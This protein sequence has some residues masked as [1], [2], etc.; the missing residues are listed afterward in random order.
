M[1]R[2]SVERGKPGG[3]GLSR[4]D[5]RLRMETRGLAVATRDDAQRALPSE[6]EEA[7][8][9]AGDP[10]VDGPGDDRHRDGLARVERHDFR[11][12]A[13][14]GEIMA[15]DGEIERADRDGGK[16]ADLDCLGAS[17][18]A[19]HGRKGE[20]DDQRGNA[21]SRP[22]AETSHAMKSPGPNMRGPGNGCR[23]TGA[24]ITTDRLRASRR[25]SAPDRCHRRPGSPESPKAMAIQT[26][27]GD[28]SLN[29]MTQDHLL[30][31]VAEE[32]D[33]SRVRTIVQ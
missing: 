21:S 24:C 17:R 3:K 25:R 11:L 30:S 16:N 12:D 31:M 6:A 29:R 9:E 18:T 27:R 8:G 4:R 23:R 26:L 13:L 7:A 10:E 33:T 19:G 5:D 1:A 14:L 28:P 20:A 32:D 2:E 22:T 15:I